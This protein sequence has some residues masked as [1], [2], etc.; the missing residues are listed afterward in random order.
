MKILQYLQVFLLIAGIA[1][2]TVFHFSNA[3]VSVTFD[4]LLAGRYSSSASVA[5]LVGFIG[6]LLYG[7]LLTAPS[8][9]RRASTMRRLNKRVRELE[10]ALGKAKPAET[11]RI[12]DRAETLDALRAEGKL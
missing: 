5:M 7:L 8:L 1:Y 9:V 12:P 6:G 11:P 3:N 10:N 4:T 2:L